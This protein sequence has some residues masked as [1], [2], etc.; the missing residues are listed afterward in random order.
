MRPKQARPGKNQNHQLFLFNHYL[1]EKGSKRYSARTRP[2]HWNNRQTPS[3]I[4]DQNF[5][6]HLTKGV[7]EDPLQDALGN[8][9]FYHFQIL[10]LVI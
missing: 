5:N 7:Q 2:D 9:Y 6:D 4:N 1:D 10:I 3:P 8:L